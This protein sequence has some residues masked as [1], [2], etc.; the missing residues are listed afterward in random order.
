[1]FDYSHMQYEVYRAEDG[2]GEPSITEMTEKAIRILNKNPKGYF[3]LVEGGRIDHGHHGGKAVRALNDAVAM[4]K[5]CGKAATMTDRDDTLLIVTADHSHVFT[6]GGYPKRGNPIFGL[7][8]E[9]DETEPDLAKDR[10]PYTVL[11]YGNGPGGERP[12]GIRQN[13]TGVDTG[14]RGYYQQATVWLSSESHGGE[15][16][17]MF[18][19]KMKSKKKEDSFGTEAR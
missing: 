6:M 13:L 1:M 3:L 17:G 10:M 12:N 11:G 8:I 19:N 15:D 4:A 7:N 18:E 14:D 16:V 9:D 2:A 5:A